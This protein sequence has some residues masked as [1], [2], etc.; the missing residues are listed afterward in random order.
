MKLLLPM[1]YA[2]MASLLPGLG[3]ARADDQARFPL[4]A[5]Y[6]EECGSCH[7]PYPPQLLPARSWKAIMAG[8]DQ[9]FGSNA[10]L[11]ATKAREIGDFLA[12]HGGGPEPRGGA[13]AKGGIALRLTETAW[14]RREHRDGHDGLAP[15]VWKSA[16]VG[17]A[18]N[19]GAC[20][21]QAAEGDYSERGIRI[22]RTN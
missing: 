22:P 13:A 7:L 9:H 8:L 20:H 16:A 21:R 19:C 14:F 11:D 12:S 10:G 18:A 2:A 15:Q 1:L 4:S 3:T 5:A 6:K 17:K